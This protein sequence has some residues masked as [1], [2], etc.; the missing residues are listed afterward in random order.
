VSDSTIKRHLHLAGIHGRRPR[1]EPL[2]KKC[3]K[4]RPLEFAKELIEEGDGYFKK[5]LWTDESKIELFPKN[6]LA[7]VWRHDGDAF[8]EDYL[9]PL[10]K[11]GGGSIM[12]WGCF[13]SAG[14]GDIAIIEGIMNSEKYQEIWDEKMLPSAHRLLEHRFTLQQDNNPKHTS[15]STKEF[16]QRKKIN[17]QQWHSQS[18][19]LNP[20]E[21]LW[22]KPKTAV[23]NC[24]P[25]NLKQL[26][27]FCKEEWA[28]ISKDRCKKLVDTYENRLQAVIDAKG[29]HTKY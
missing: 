21:M 20:I 13:S 17:V 2:L 11:H 3:H 22:G 26:A 6:G 5:I 4:I 19:D 18:P 28:K 29:G 10:V 14:T 27:E 8:K 15:R 12:I 16:F 24:H 1:K 23:G 25:S 7:Y 9:V